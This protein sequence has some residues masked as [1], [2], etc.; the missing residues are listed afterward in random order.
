MTVDDIIY[1]RTFQRF[2]NSFG[3]MIEEAS[4]LCNISWGYDSMGRNTSFTLPDASSITR[5]YFDGHLY[6]VT[7]RDPEGIP[8]YA[9]TYL[10]T[11]LNGHVEE[12]RLIY[13]LAELHTKHDL[14][15]RPYLQT[16]P[17]NTYQV[18][19]DSLGR[20]EYINHSLFQEKRSPMIR[21]IN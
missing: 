20:V 4:P 13:N 15:E 10:T 2:Y 16:S 1:G 6:S 17:W 21:S 18:G 11:D 3:E 9:H 8:L 12:E 5:E 19:Y 7:R 14:L